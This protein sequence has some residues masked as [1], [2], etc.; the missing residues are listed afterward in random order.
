VRRRAYYKPR[1]VTPEGSPGWPWIFRKPPSR[2]ERIRASLVGRTLKVRV[3]RRF[4]AGPLEDYFALGTYWSIPVSPDPGTLC[5]VRGDPQI[6]IRQMQATFGLA[7]A[8]L[9]A[10][11]WFE[12]AGFVPPGWTWFA[13]TTRGA[14]SPDEALL[15]RLLGE[16]V[17]WLGEVRTLQAALREIEVPGRCTAAGD[18]EA[19]RRRYYSLLAGVATDAATREIDGSPALVDR[20]LANALPFENAGDAREEA[21]WRLL[22]GALKRAGEEDQYAGTDRAG[23][24]WDP[25]LPSQTLMLLVERIGTRAHEIALAAQAT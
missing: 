2:F 6:H 23:H 10:Y 7:P 15:Q 22:Q 19:L 11:D 25:Y 24:R 16:D 18:V 21:R 20:I 5:F 9:L 14:Y 4:A 12:R 3:L 1:V 13:P 17:D 8:S